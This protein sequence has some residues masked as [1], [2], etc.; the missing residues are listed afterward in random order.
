MNGAA[1]FTDQ[2]Q[3]GLSMRFHVQVDDINLGGWSSCDGLNV[4]FGLKS[5]RSGGN[6]DYR[7]W[8]PDGITYSKLVLKRAMSKHSSAVIMGWLRTMI[9]PQKSQG[10]TITLL[11]SHSDEVAQWTLRNV[12]PSSWK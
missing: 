10:A 7:A 8:V 6:N 11:D 1:T 12:R 9:D 5:I 3:F 2:T 4:D